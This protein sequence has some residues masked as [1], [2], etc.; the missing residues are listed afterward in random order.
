MLQGTT[1][2]YKHPKAHTL[3]LTIPARIVQDST[4]PF[5]AGDM[6]SVEWHVS[7][8]LTIMKKEMKK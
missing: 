3:Y 6:V 1:K 4:F 8:F 5:K 2:L 7:G